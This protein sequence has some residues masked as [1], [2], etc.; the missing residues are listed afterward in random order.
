MSPNVP[1]GKRKRKRRQYRREVAVEQTQY[2]EPCRRDSEQSM[3]ESRYPH[4]GFRYFQ[5]QR[6]DSGKPAFSGIVTLRLGLVSLNILDLLALSR[7]GWVAGT[8]CVERRPTLAGGR[9]PL[10]SLV[11]TASLRGQKRHFIT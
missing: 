5:G 6:A 9:Q 1:P 2:G 3:A 11:T 10:D 8:G 7:A 4:I